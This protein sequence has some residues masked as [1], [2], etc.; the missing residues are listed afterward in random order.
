MARGVLFR[1]AIRGGQQ[2]CQTHRSLLLQ[3]PHAGT[4]M[5]RGDLRDLRILPAL[6]RDDRV[7][8]ECVAQTGDRGSGGQ[9]TT[10]QRTADTGHSGRGVRVV[11]LSA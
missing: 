11:F 1:C 2:W 4:P 10:G 5:V 7:L 9:A 3:R 6:G 8:R